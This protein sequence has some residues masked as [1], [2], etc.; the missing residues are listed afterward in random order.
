[1]LAAI[2]SVLA[3]LFLAG[4][5]TA[6]STRRAVTRSDAFHITNVDSIV[7]DRSNWIDGQSRH[8]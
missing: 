5:S 3:A 8:F 1:V 2:L 7:N 4:C 6:P